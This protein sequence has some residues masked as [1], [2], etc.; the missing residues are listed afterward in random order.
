MK[1]PLIRRRTIGLLPALA[2]GAVIGGLISSHLH[3]S[4]GAPLIA[5]PPTACSGL[6]QIS[7]TDLETVTLETISALRR[8]QNRQSAYGRMTEGGD[9][10]RTPESR[11]RAAAGLENMRRLLP[12]AQRL[13]IESIRSARSTRGITPLT[14]SREIGLVN[15]I[16][17]I[18]LDET[19]PNVAEVRDDK[20]STIFVGFD[21]ALDLVSDD[22]A[23]F[24]LGHELTHVAAWGD[25]LDSLIDRVS[26]QARLSADV[27]AS[28]DQDEDLTCDLIG[29]EAL[30]RFIK[31]EPTAEPEGL[32]L[33]RVLGYG[34]DSERLIVALG[35]FCASFNGERSDDEHLSSA[36]TVRAL[37][38]LEPEF[39]ASI[40]DYSIAPAFCR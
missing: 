40:P 32:R 18:V 31:I 36:E 5:K 13:T 30:K 20:P 25:R 39:K 29:A 21:Y 7:R 1:I 14:F 2:V 8:R 35:D 27:Q 37:V 10:A 3:I 23:V 11:V 24:L 15:S 12:L 6:D 16:H 19:L 34:T 22:E 17:N 26:Q 4:A 38:G 9:A 33:A 28:I